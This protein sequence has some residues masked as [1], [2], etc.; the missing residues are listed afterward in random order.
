MT[1][2]IHQTHERKCAAKKDCRAVQPAM[3]SSFDTSVD[4]FCPRRICHPASRAALAG[5]AATAAG[6]TA[7]P[8]DHRLSGFPVTDHTENDQRD[9]HKEDNGHQDGSGLLD[10]GPATLPHGTEYGADFRQMVR[11]KHLTGWSKIKVRPL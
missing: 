11:R 6:L 1:G 4:L 7:S 9:D 10:E 3:Q 5:T 8:A 2:R